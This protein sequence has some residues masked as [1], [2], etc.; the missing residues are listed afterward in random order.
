[1]GLAS[2]ADVNAGEWARGY[3]LGKQS[4]VKTQ[5]LLNG[6]EGFESTA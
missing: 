4:C 5:L 3:P 2:T 6:T 1:M